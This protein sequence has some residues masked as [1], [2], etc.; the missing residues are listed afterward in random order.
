M[1]LSLLSF[2]WSADVASKDRRTHLPRF[3]QLLFEVVGVTKNDKAVDCEYL[4]ITSNHDVRKAFVVIVS[5]RVSESVNMIQIRTRIY[6]C[7]E[8]P[9]ASMGLDPWL[10][11]NRNDWVFFGQGGWG[12]GPSRV[13]SNSSIYIL[14]IGMSRKC[15]ILI[16]SISHHNFILCQ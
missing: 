13:A 15:I 9:N 1:I 5:M 14:L 11:R 16:L 8:A 4:A 6:P 3:S 12:F 7:R 10:A 2:S